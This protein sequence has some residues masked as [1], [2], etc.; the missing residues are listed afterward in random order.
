MF[1]SCR[2]SAY[3]GP[4]FIHVGLLEPG[5]VGF[6]H[7]CP[8]WAYVVLV[9]GLC[10]TVL[11]HVGIIHARQGPCWGLYWNVC[12]YVKAWVFQSP[13]CSIRRILSFRTR[14]HDEFK[15]VCVFSPKFFPWW[16]MYLSSDLP[17]YLLIYLCVRVS[18]YA[19]VHLSMYFS[20]SLSLSFSLSISLSPSICPSFFLS[21]DRFQKNYLLQNLCVNECMHACLVVCMYARTYVCTYVC[22]YACMHACMYVGM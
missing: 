6:G 10:W 18:M 1:G 7:V 9:L 12:W 20:Q 14:L 15:T 19:S 16:S 2:V 5:D 22:M 11:G 8:R 17:I 3:V 13:S 4:M 21:I